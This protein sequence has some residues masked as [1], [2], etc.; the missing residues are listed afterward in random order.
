MLNA[1]NYSALSGYDR[2]LLPAHT[3]AVRCLSWSRLNISEGSPAETLQFVFSFGGLQTSAV[4][5]SFPEGTL[6]CA[7][8]GMLLYADRITVVPA[9]R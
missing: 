3:Q 5:L 7:P 4:I 6:F 8:Q 2:L 9:V 1:A